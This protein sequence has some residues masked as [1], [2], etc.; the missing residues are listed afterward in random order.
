M[1]GRRVWGILEDLV[2]ALLPFY[3]SADIAIWLYRQGW[4]G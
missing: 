2:F 3:F 1:K 4:F